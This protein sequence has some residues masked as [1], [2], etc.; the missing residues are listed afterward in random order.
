MCIQDT[1]FEGMVSAAR[2]TPSVSNFIAQ[3]GTTGLVGDTTFHMFSGPNNGLP[4][5]YVKSTYP[6][7][8]LYF[9]LCNDLMN[10]DPVIRYA[11]ESRD[12]FF[13]SDLILSHAEMRMMKLATGFGV[14]V[15]GFSVPTSDVGPY[16]GLFSICA[17]PGRE[18]DWL[19]NVRANR[20]NIEKIASSL[21]RQARQ[22]IDPY[23]G[24]AVHLSR[25]EVECLRHIAEGKTHT[26]MAEILDL[27]EHTVRSYCRSVRLKLNC[28][29]LAQ[30]VAKACATGIL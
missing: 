13:W 10:I 16:R 20:A 3:F 30:A 19:N 11:Q 9:Y 6:E 7:S 1:D 26:D 24:Y 29:T 28:S 27:S 4:A 14:S 5:P 15:T 18:A 2:S 21:H 17:V 22:E 25:R 8:W 23:E 12:P